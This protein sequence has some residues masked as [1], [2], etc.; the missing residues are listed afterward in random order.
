MSDRIFVFAENRSGRNGWAVMRRICC[1]CESW[2]SGGI[3][4]FLQN[5]LTRLDLSRIEVDIVAAQLEN[6][7]FTK[8][9]EERGVR[10]YELSGSTRNVLKNAVMFREL[11]RQRQYDL[12]HFNIFQGLALLYVYIAKRE[13]VPRRIAHSHNTALR[14]SPT[15]QLKLLVHRTAS[16]LFAGAATELWACSEPAARFMFPEKFLRKRG[17]TF[18]PNGIDT[19]KFRFDPAGRQAARAELGLEEVLAVGNIGR[20]CYQ[21]NQDFLLDIF[22]EILRF[23]P[24]SRL[25]LIGEGE[26]RKALEDKAKR[27]GIIDKTMFLGVRRDAERLFWAMDVFAFPTRFEGLGIVAVEAQ[28]AGLPI[29]CS[30]NV[31]NEVDITPIVRRL[32]LSDGAGKWAETLLS[33]SRTDKAE[34]AAALVRRAGFDVADVARQIE[35]V[36]LR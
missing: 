6:S 26:D 11:L 18:I 28:A 35:S 16:R 33:L 17:F 31:P 23:K 14:K 27:L 12:V 2:K 20:L 30:E 13:G 3:E 32:D 8:E 22:A 4:S 25:L 21:K 5:V 36:Y 24:D 15:R 19:A 34:D 7:I 1:F 10:F 9:L 29:V